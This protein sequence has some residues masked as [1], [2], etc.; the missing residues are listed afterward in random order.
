MTNSKPFIAP[1]VPPSAW[2]M[3][4]YADAPNGVS[5]QY[6]SPARLAST[7]DAY[8]AWKHCKDVTRDDGRT[9]DLFELLQNSLNDTQYAFPP[10]GWPRQVRM[11]SPR[12]YEMP[13]MVMERLSGCQTVAF[14]GV[15]P[16]INRRRVSGDNRL[17]LA[18]LNRA[19]DVPIVFETTDPPLGHAGVCGRR[20]RASPPSAKQRM[21][22]AT[23]RQ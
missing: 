1:P 3:E 11:V 10:K 19:Q 5:A 15:Y 17:F 9:P 6:D 2:A 16:L 18:G 7:Q 23:R 12:V 14:C 4:L 13:K 22:R 20:P 21:V 8:D